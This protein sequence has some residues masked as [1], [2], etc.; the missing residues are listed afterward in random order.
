MTIKIYINKKP[1][2]SYS[3]KELEEIKKELTYRAFS[4]A[5]YVRKE[6]ANG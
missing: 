6:K 3:E 2:E 5:G 4:A 1:L